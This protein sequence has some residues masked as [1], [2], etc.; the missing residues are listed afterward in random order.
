MGRPVTLAEP[1][2]ERLPHL[3]LRDRAVDVLWHAHLIGPA[4]AALPSDLD[5]VVRNRAERIRH[6]IPDVALA[7]AVHVNGIFVEARGENLRMPHRTGPGRAH[8]R[9][10]HMALLHDPQ[11]QQ[12]L[13]AKLLLA[14]AK[15]SLRGE[16]ADRAVWHSGGAI[17]GLA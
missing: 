3:R 11:R 6:R 1:R 5:Q 14:P 9:G 13:L 15:I 7:V 16:R 4:A 17:A 12:K 2:A 8:G 10:R